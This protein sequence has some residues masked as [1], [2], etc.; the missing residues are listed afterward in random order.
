MISTTRTLVPYIIGFS[1]LLFFWGSGP[2][3][4]FAQDTS[5]SLPPEIVGP[6][7]IGV[8]T[9]ILE[10]LVADIRF[11]VTVR[12]AETDEPVTPAQ[13]RIVSRNDAR[14]TSGWAIAL[15]T[16]QKPELYRAEV[17][18]DA[19]GIWAPQ[20]QVVSSLGEAIL[21]LQTIP[22]R[23]TN[24]STS[25]AYAFVT[26]FAVLI[27]GSLYVIWRIRQTQRRSREI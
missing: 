22:V 16:P 15:N 9:I 14:D 7:K 20:V 17:H 5:R 26:T 8:T 27:A 18:Y 19:E 12:N 13:V 21:D 6:Y 25:G 24:P 23:H 11:L 3:P 10:P 4:A 2:I 1:A